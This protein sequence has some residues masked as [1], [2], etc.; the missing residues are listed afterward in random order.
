MLGLKMG[1]A[2]RLFC[3][4][5]ALGAQ[6]LADSEG[7]VASPSEVLERFREL[8]RRIFGEQAKGGDQ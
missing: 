8:N 5:Y 1:R 7:G 4:Y 6:L 3:E 2:G